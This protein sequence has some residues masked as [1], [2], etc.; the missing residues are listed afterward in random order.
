MRHEIEKYMSIKPCASCQGARLKK[1][2][3]SVLVG[4]LNISQLT[5]KSVLDARQFLNQLQLSERESAIA[6]LVLKEINERLEFL[7]NVGLDYLTLERTAGTLS[8]GEAQ[9]IR[10]ATQIGSSLVGVLYILDEPSI[11]LHQ[12]DNR[13]LIE[14]L[15][16]L[17]DLGNTVIVVEHDEEMMREADFIVDIGPGAGAHGGKV[18]AAGTLKEIMAEPASITGQYLTGKQQIEVPKERRKPNGKYLEIKGAK[19]H[20]LKNIDVKIPL[21]V[22]V[23]ITGVSG[24]GKST[25]INDILYPVTATKLNRATTLQAGTHEKII[26]LE[27]LDKVID[28][29]QSPIGRTPR[30]PSSAAS[31]MRTPAAPALRS[32]RHA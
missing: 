19:E 3:R 9:R 5:T 11:G 18:V 29:D 31:V 21:G 16:E 6:H 25:L 20:N 1:E 14:T 15:K 24:S 23:C 28:I 8:G 30:H 12:R 13:R 10:L 7:I 2:S 17:R 22:F 32:R 4:G 27:H 26:G